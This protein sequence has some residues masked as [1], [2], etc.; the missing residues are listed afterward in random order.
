MT[1]SKPMNASGEW[2]IPDWPAPRRVR[3]A[4][5]T[6][7]GPGVSVGPYERL[8]LG[9]R[10]GDAPEA[11]AA[12]RSAV[13][14]ALQLERAPHWLQQVHGIDVADVDRLD[15]EGEPRADAAVT[16][17]AG[18]PLA[19]LTADCLPVL[20]CTLDGGAVAAAHAGWRGLVA[21]V[22]EATLASLPAPPAQVMTWLG[23]CIGAPSYEVGEEVRDA[24]LAA[25]AGSEHCFVPT[26]PG[27]WLCDLAGLARRRLLA[28]GIA[29]VHGG[30]FDTRTDARFYSYRRDGASSGRFASLIWR[31]G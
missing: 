3:A 17:R 13:L 9:I 4:V 7:Q 1:G 31:E 20:F 14:T 22:L 6:C 27:H 19:I 30:G 11:V 12:N 2:I 29:S 18:E 8:N 28:A 15:S 25:D 24:F 21:G 26:R 16:C 23:P 5:S 10:S